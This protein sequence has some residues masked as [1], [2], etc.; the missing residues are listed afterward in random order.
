M[1]TVGILGPEAFTPGAVASAVAAFVTASQSASLAP[2][3]AVGLLVTGVLLAAG[4]EFGPF[5]RIDST[6]R[7]A[8]ATC[9]ICEHR[10]DPG[11]GECPYCRT[12]D[13]VET[14]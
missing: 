4:A 7:R 14:D 3:L 2:L 9:R 11:R 1:L 10:I 8:T 6:R 5:G 13:P 12:D